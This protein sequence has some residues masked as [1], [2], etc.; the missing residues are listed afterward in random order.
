MD[1][2]LKIS[3]VNFQLDSDLNNLLVTSLMPFLKRSFNPLCSV[4]KCIIVNFLSMER[5]NHPEFQCALTV[6]IMITISTVSLNDMQPYIMNDFGNIIV[7]RLVIL[8]HLNDTRKKF[9]RHRLG[10]CRFLINHWL[11]LSHNSPYA[12]IVSLFTH[13]SSLYPYFTLF[14]C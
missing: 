11:S 6:K 1:H 3:A 9:Q 2:F 7:L 8:F 14:V 10:Q 4:T 12:M 5:E 13:F